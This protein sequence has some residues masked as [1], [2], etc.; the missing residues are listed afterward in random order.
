MG[1]QN[2][3]PS[4]H[5]AWRL[6][7]DELRGEIVG[8]S[9]PA[10]SKL[11]S[12]AALAERFDVHRHTVR[13][14]VAA[15][16]ADELVVP[17]RGSGTFVAEHTVLVHRIGVRTRFTESLG[18]RGGSASGHLLESAQESAPPAEVVDRLRLGDRPALRLDYVRRV[19]G[20]PLAR[21]TA[22][23]DAER[24][25]RLVDHFGPEG[26]ITAAL[27]AIGIDDYVRTST[28]VAGRAAT[29]A[30]ARDLDLPTGSIVLVVRAL[31][32]LPSGSPLLYNVT[33]FAAARVELDVEHTAS[34]G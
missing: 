16:A 22:W 25:P 3:S 18:P 17:R 26:S 31:N 12:E 19:D 33:R 11:P 28:T 29:A 2:R 21:A 8:G 15:L 4:G 24:V 10:G 27:R 9:I 13:H 32:T 6:I 30:E 5:S 1:N 7:A 34:L 14:A 23:F 20:L